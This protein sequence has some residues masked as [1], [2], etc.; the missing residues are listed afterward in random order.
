MCD[1]EHIS[2]F[3]PVHGGAQ[4]GENVSTVYNIPALAFKLTD[5]FHSKFNYGSCL[6]IASHDFFLSSSL[7]VERFYGI[8]P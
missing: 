5:S 4:P 2:I 1:G 8:H 7:Y 3:V 6:L